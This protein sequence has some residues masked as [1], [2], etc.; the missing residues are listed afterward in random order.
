MPPPEMM[1]AEAPPP[2][3]LRKKGLGKVLGR[4]AHLALGA[5]EA[6]HVLHHPDDGQLHLVAEADFLPHIL[7]GHLLPRVRKPGI[8]VKM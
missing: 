2:P 1:G 7:E 4:R 8:S 5:H 6:T 3:L